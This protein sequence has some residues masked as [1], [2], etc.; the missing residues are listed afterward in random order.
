M[1]IGVMPEEKLGFWRRARYYK[2][3]G[4]ESI[5]MQISCSPL[6]PFGP[7]TVNETLRRSGIRLIL[8]ALPNAATST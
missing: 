4:G 7:T 5:H 2:H 8:F 1:G 3:E 6:P